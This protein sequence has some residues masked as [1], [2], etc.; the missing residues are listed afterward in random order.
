MN[1]K[2]IVLRSVVLA[3][4]LLAMLMGGVV[5]SPVFGGNGEQ[6]LERAKEAQ[7]RH[8]DRL[9]ANPDVVGTAVGKSAAGRPAV[10]ILTKVPG[11]ARLPAEL[12]G[13]PVVVKVTGEIVALPGPLRGKPPKPPK[14]PGHGGGGDKV[15]PTSRFDRPVPIGVSTG[16]PDITAGTIGARVKDEEGDVYALSNNH[17]YA[18]ENNASIGDNVL[19][20]GPYDG[21]IDPDDAIGTL[22]D[23]EPIK[24]D[25]SANTIDAAIALSSGDMLTNTTPSDGYG[26]PKSATAEAV[27]GQRVQKYGRTTSLTKGKITQINATVKVGY[28]SGTAV[29]VDQII[30][31]SKKPVIKGGDS[32]SLLVTD[33]GRNPVGLLFAGNA[34][35]KLAVANDIDEVLTAFGVTIDGE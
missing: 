24:F 22:F 12:D 28:S 32:G 35:G 2:R 26:T 6:G 17:V 14:P 8:T 33:A 19:Q 21:G 15:D 18:N 7:E 4:V 10:L 11:V 25:G 20:P 1:K 9:M 34:N 31:E 27:L 16:H 23:F 3:L 30:V 5:G 29:F 13:V